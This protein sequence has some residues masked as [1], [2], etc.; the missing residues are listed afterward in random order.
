MVIILASRLFFNR[1][2]NHITNLMF[3]NDTS[4]FETQVRNLGS[5]NQ[6]G[7]QFS[8]TFKIG[9]ATFN[10]YIKIYGLQTSR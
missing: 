9:F 3:I 2:T 1:T 10:P 7:L 4:T 6:L 8:G 5:V